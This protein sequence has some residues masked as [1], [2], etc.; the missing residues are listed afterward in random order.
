MIA[1]EFKVNGR[2]VGGSIDAAALFRSIAQGAPYGNT[3]TLL[4][5]NGERTFT[6]QED[7]CCLN[8]QNGKVFREISLI[9]DDEKFTITEIRI[10]DVITLRDF[11]TVF[12][13]QVA[14]SF[15]FYMG[16]DCDKAALTAGDNDFVAAL[17]GKKALG[18]LGCV[19]GD[20]GLGNYPVLLEKIADKNILEAQMF[21][22][23]E[24]LRLVTPKLKGGPEVI[25]TSD[26]KPFLHSRLT[27]KSDEP[28][29]IA[30]ICNEY[31]SFFVRHEI[32]EVVSLTAGSTICD[33]VAVFP[34]IA[35]VKRG[36]TL[37][38]E[39]DAI[40][41]GEPSHKFAAVKAGGIL[42]L[43]SRGSGFPE[44]IR[45]APCEG[46]FALSTDGA[47][48]VASSDGVVVYAPS[49][50]EY[51][52]DLPEADSAVIIDEGDKYHFALKKDGF[53][54]R[55]A[56]RKDSGELTLLAAAGGKSMGLFRASEN[57]IGY[58]DGSVVA[59][60][61]TDS[62]REF[63]YPFAGEPDDFGFIS[64]C[65][66]YS[67]KKSG[68]YRL[69]T[70]FD[71]ICDFV[72]CDGL[73]CSE[74]NLFSLN[75]KAVLLAEGVSSAALVDDYVI[76]AEKD[77]VALYYAFKKDSFA[78]SDKVAQKAYAF[79]FYENLNPL[80]ENAFVAFV[81]GLKQKENS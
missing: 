37:S 63:D 60:V 19:C 27:Q 42:S 50:R 75:D 74:G 69:G 52:L 51:R 24:T 55:Y 73:A 13:K 56:L 39:T 76:A 66:Y 20:F 9:A 14:V 22:D 33:D 18:K 23:G 44:V 15:S 71:L 47:L 26:G 17:L 30:G 77:C 61:T 70:S 1:A 65:R 46:T 31:G 62:Y 36:S 68:N 25:F 21:A 8:I 58:R 80:T 16:F 79:K 57:A 67:S 64:D 43:Y 54:L 32:A 11:R 72:G 48:L 10:G 12:G 7:F 53:L 34:M 40:V 6:P 2:N 35:S 81:F 78:L 38:E 29:T 45:S 41:A 3:V 59:I 5:E 4:T 28:V 49:G